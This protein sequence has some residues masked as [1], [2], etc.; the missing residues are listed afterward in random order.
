ME[1]IRWHQRFSNY[2]KALNKLEG[3][4]AYIKDE[5]DHLNLEDEGVYHDIFLTIADIV[6]Q[7]LIQSFEFTHE[8]AWNVLKDYLAYQGNTEVHGSRD[9]VRES[10][11]LN[12]I[13]QGDA[14]MDMI[15]S[16]NKTSH[17]YNEQTANEIFVS[18]I[19]IYFP[20]FKH[21]ATTL[22]KI[23]SGEQGTL[24]TE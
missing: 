6:K 23:R 22:E 7:G 13:D 24:F 8:L 4:I 19:T 16:R 2:I 20:L 14:W 17:T 15:L 12:I 1:D 18:I 5:F 9:T 3:N 21:L 10:L 11:K